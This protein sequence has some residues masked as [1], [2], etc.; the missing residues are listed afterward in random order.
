MS[1][2]VLPLDGPEPHEFKPGACAW[3]GCGKWHTNEIHRVAPA[4][5]ESL[6]VPTGADHPETS[7]AAARRVRLTYG[8]HLRAVYDMIAAAREG[9]TAD[10]VDERTGWGH[11]SSSSAVSSL[12]HAGWIS[13]VVDHDTGKTIKRK[14][15]KGSGAE[16]MVVVRRLVESA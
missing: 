9:M 13:S 10:E 1:Q 15:R 16:V 2:D 12:K 11:S 6:D 8:S 14:T 3:P 7:R 4:P 5:I